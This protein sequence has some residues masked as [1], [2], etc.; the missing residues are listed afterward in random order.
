MDDQVS[1]EEEVGGLVVGYN[2]HHYL[3]HSPVS[4]GLVID[5]DPFCLR[6]LEEELS[7]DLLG[8]LGVGDE[9]GAE[10]YFGLGVG[11]DDVLRFDI[12]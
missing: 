9:D 11:S 2:V 6:E 4:V 8:V 10:G 12:I 1:E 7:V 5:G 3:L